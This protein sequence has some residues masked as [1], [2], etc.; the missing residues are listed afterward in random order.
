MNEQ[1]INFISNSV[2]NK[3]YNFNNL[4]NINYLGLIFVI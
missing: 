2:K 4:F 3:N 1:K